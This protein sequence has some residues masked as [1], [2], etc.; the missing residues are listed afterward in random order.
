VRVARELLG[1][2]CGDPM[3]TGREEPLSAVKQENL[4]SDLAAPTKLSGVA[5]P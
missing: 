4:V 2:L 3:R 1:L 5:G